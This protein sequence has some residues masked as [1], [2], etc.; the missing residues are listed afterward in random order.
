[1]N[2][3]G[4]AATTFTSWSDT[5]I[6]VTVPTGVSTGNVTVT[7]AGITTVGPVY[8]VTDT[9]TVTDSLGNTTTYDGEI[10]AGQWVMA[11][12][13]GSGCSSCSVRG[14]YQNTYDSRGNVLTTTDPLSHVITYTYTTVPTI[15]FLKQRHSQPQRHI[16]ITVLVKC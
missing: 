3:W 8:T 4:A 6:T 16:P 11:S 1:M 10:A 2:F 9:A 12:S 15:C 13:T 7:V 5:S 14:T